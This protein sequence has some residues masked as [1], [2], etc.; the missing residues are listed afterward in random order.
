[1][2]CLLF[3]VWCYVLF[4]VC[5]LVWFVVCCCWLVGVNCC[6]LLSFVRCSLFVAG[7]WLCIA[8]CVLF[9]LCFVLHVVLFADRG[10]LC[11]VYC[12]VRVLCAC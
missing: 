11:V 12:S 9:A 10:L 2:T 1:M 7:C 8:R 6:G 3:A 4:V 5:L